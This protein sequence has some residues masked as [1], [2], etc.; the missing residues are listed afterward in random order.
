M[1]APEPGV[2]LGT[3]AGRL[4]AAATVVAP[5]SV[6]G[7]LL[8]YFGYVAT[9]ARYAFFGI[10]LTALDLSF[11]DLTLLGTEVVYLPLV[12]LVVAA[13]VLALLHHGAVVALRGPRARPA[14][15]IAGRVG[16]AVG[17]VLFLRGV[18]GMVWPG[19][20]PPWVPGLTPLALGF[21]LP[22]AGYGWWLAGAGRHR[23]GP[24]GLLR[25]GLVVALVTLA[26]AG[27]FWAAN[28]FAVTYG[29]N[30]AAILAASLHTRPA[31]VLDTA[32]RLYLTIPGVDERILPA[33]AG[34][35]FRYRYR[36]LRVLTE[37]AGK[38]YLVPG[39]WA[40][41]A[42]TV[43]VPYTAEVRVQFVPG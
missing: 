41:R 4:H 42:A 36:G 10:D 20:V 40:G 39:V 3:V 30:R 14:V 6:V 37:A 31:V 7:G 8:F 9:A 5:A 26:V 15:R 2:G 35:R 1:P 25:R 16:V 13:V 12:G 38:L 17:A 32:E 24:A 33:E 18:A 34:Q 21:G 11:A 28:T 23:G 19:M 27:T 22:V 29:R 43:V